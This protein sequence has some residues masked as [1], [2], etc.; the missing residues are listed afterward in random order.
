VIAAVATI[1]TLDGH[2]PVAAIEAS[3]A[4]RSQLLQFYLAATVLTV[5]PIAGE[6]SRRDIVFRTLREREAR[7]RLITER[8]SDT[9]LTMKL[10][11]TIVFASASSLKL[12]GPSAETLVGVN[13]LSLVHAA[14][15]EAVAETHRAAIAEPGSS[16]RIA[17]RLACADGLGRWLESNATAYTDE[18][19]NAIGVVT[20]VRDV[21]ERKRSELRLVD[22]ANTDAL[23]CLPN[24]R[25]FMTQLDAIG[26][27][28]TGAA[29]GCIAII[30]LDH[31][32]AITDE[33]GE[34]GGDAVLVHFAGLLRS[35]LRG[36]DF[37][38][39]LGGEEFAIVLPHANVGQ[40]LGVCDRIRQ[41]ASAANI[42]FAG[43]RI[44]VTASI[45]LA[46]W[47]GGSSPF[48]A[49]EQADS[50]LYTAKRDGRDCARMAA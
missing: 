8:S 40:A 42:A 45:G 26:A 25:A 13:A 17:Y 29:F 1:L 3:A 2:G 12:G 34:E 36:G 41:A 5:W 16:Q 49:L 33:H 30:D 6:L 14:D 48:L 20:V 10:D 15:R 47:T 31:F 18:E 23:T 7:Y 22:A 4:S 46:S 27:S 39:R 37:A 50:A 32:K 35:N 28:A 21:S 11:G 24:R 9:L 44:E 19:G 38:A 43:T